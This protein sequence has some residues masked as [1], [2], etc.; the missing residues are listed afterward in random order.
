MIGTILGLATSAGSSIFGGIKAHKENERYKK[1]LNDLQK[2]QNDFYAER[3]NQ[4]YTQ[5]ADVQRLLARASDE[6]R[7]QI[8]AAQGAQAVMGG[9]DQAVN[10]ARSAANAGLANTYAQVASQAG[11]YKDALDAQQQKNEAGMSQAWQNYYAQ[12][13]ANSQSAASQGMKAG[14]DLVQADANYYLNGKDY[15]DNQGNLI[16]SRD[17]FLDMFR[18]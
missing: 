2:K 6:A 17:L 10:D 1:E 15:Y 5:R 3:Y 13:A 18:R 14:M 16:K 12:S 4:D 11:A 9:S 8:Q 7:K